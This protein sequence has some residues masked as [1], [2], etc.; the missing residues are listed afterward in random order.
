MY[1]ASPHSI[2]IKCSSINTATLNC[3][4]SR[5][6]IFTTWAGSQSYRGKAQRRKVACRWWR[7]DFPCSKKKKRRGLINGKKSEINCSTNGQNQIIGRLLGKKLSRT[8][9]FHRQGTAVPLRIRDTSSISYTPACSACPA[10]AS[11]RCSCPVIP[12]RACCG[13]CLIQSME[14]T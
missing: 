10:R 6:R 8:D 3:Q 14:G 4:I 11:C 12:N 7:T 9:K 5:A 13:T 1:R 2:V